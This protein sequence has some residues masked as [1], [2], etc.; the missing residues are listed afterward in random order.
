MDHEI[1]SSQLGKDLAGWDWTCMQLDDGT[2]VK[3]YRLRKEDGSSDRWSAVYWIDQE[4]EIEQVY[5]DKFT[6]SEEDEWTSP[7]TGLTYPTDVLIRARH[8]IEGEKSYRLR[9]VLDDQ[10]FYGNRADNAYWEGACDVLN[11]G[12]QVIGRAYLELAGYGGGLGA[13]L[14]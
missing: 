6:W 5:A 1:S 11:A 14:N 3:A 12:G 10:E 7:T 9:P 4:G 13:R 8:P 2:E